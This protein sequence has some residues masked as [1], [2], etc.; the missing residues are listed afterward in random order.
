MKKPTRNELQLIGDLLFIL[1]K[2][3]RNNR[4]AIIWILSRG[5]ARVSHRLQRRKEG[6]Q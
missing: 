5:R 3:T 6:T 2:G 4:Q 1:R